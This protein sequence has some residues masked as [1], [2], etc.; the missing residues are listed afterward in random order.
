MFCEK[1][2]T[3]VDDGQ[4]F[5]PNCG[6][7]LDAAAPTPNPAV[8][9]AAA[10]APQQKASRKSSLGGLTGK[11]STKQIFVAATCFLLVLGLLMSW[12][13]VLGHVDDDYDES[14]EKYEE[15]LDELKDMDPD[16]YY[17]SEKELEKEIERTEKRLD[18]L[19]DRAHMHFYLADVGGGWLLIIVTILS[20][21]AISVAVLYF[22]GKVNDPKLLLFTGCAAG[23]MF[24]LLTIK[25]IA[26]YEDESMHLS[27]AGWLMFLSEL[28]A[29]ALSVLGFLQAKKN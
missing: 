8:G 19:K 25:W 15:M 20:T 9:F 7:R 23:L 5:C 3:R 17:G 21:L 12:C 26:G 2:G 27:V 13:K 29:A 22:L 24:L 14:I 1:C 16:D 6:N 11:F 4:P 10:P 18:E 28:G